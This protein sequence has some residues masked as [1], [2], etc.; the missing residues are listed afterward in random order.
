MLGRFPQPGDS[1]DFGD[2]RVTVETVDKR[3]VEQIHIEPK[4]TDEVEH[5]EDADH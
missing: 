4:P 3:R 1:F 5:D 2:W